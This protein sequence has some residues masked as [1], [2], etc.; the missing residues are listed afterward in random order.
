MASMFSFVS[1]KL[2]LQSPVLAAPG[3]AAAPGYA[4]VGA[5]G[6]G[7]FSSIATARLGWSLGS[8]SHMALSL[9]GGNPILTLGMNNGPGWQ[10]NTGIHLQPA[11]FLGWTPLTNQA[12]SSADTQLFRGP[13]A[14]ILQLRSGTTAQELQIL[15]TYTSDTDLERLAIRT[16]AGA[17]L[18]SP[19]ALDNGILR[20]LNL[21]NIG[22]IDIDASATTDTAPTD[23]T[24]RKKLTVQKLSSAPTNATYWAASNNPGSDV[25]YL[26]MEE[27]S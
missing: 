2:V 10:R 18:I 17:Y 12:S 22:E 4:F 21:G 15:G 19:E 26:V 23:D 14:G 25:F 1:G 9:S 5:P 27:G 8:V 6:D 24:S 20:I 3:T 7:M 11:E 16:A 13:S